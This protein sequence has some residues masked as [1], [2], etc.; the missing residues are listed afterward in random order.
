M[1]TAAYVSSHREKTETTRRRNQTMCEYK[2]WLDSVPAQRRPALEGSTSFDVLQFL[3]EYWGQ[4]HTGKCDMLKGAGQ[5][6]PGY[7][8]GAVAALATGFREQGLP[9]AVNPALQPPVRLPVSCPIL[10]GWSAVLVHRA[11][12]GFATLI[13]VTIRVFVGETVR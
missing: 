8:A 1:A 7:L 6:A 2:A 10:F 11:E 9:D 3:I 12:Y 5:A 4:R 13:I